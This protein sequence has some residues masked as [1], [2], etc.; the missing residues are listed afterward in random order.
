MFKFEN[1]RM[2]DC[3]DIELLLDA[4][5][6]ADRFN[7]ASYSLRDG[8]APIS[9]LSMVARCGPQLVGTVRFWPVLVHDLILA[10]NTE[11]LL[12]G[13][14]AVKPELVGQG[15]GSKLVEKALTR[16]D[17]AGYKRV[18]LVGDCDY[19]AQFGF[20]PVLPSYIT[21]PGGRDARRLCVRQSTALKSLPAVGKV[22][23]VQPPL[24]LA[25]EFP[26]AATG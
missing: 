1:E 2:S 26:I 4:A 11:A 12:L 13:P 14:L 7:K 5:F 17:G 18:L 20:R 19:Y 3:A 16:V 9:S 24:A 22:L 10:E 8:V 23:S 21:L 15:I 25:E 6:G